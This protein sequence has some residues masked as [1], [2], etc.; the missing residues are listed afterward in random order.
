MTTVGLFGA[1]SAGASAPSI[2]MK[3]QPSFICGA[4]AVTVASRLTSCRS[5]LLIGIGRHIVMTPSSYWSLSMAHSDSLDLSM[6]MVR[7]KLL[8][9]GNACLM[10]H[11]AVSQHEAQEIQTDAFNVLRDK[12]EQTRLALDSYDETQRRIELDIS[13][14]LGGIGL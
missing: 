2:D 10:A 12:F 11:W 9:L 5:L 6:Q 14:A 7:I 1:E 13:R 4:A 8:E 3:T